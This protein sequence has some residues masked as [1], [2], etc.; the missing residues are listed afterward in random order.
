MF[1]TGSK[2]MIG[3]TALTTI[4][5]VAY[6]LAVGGT[7]GTIGLASAAVAL[8]F[9]SGIVI[10]I[11][12]ANVDVVDSAAAAR[13]AAG[14]QAPSA[15]LWPLVAI[16]GLTMVVVGL[17]STP[18]VFILGFVVLLAAGV[19]W[20]VQAWAEQ[21]SAD[22]TYNAEIRDRIIGPL[23]VPI[24]AALVGVLVIYAFSRIMLTLSKTGSIVAFS[25]VATIILIV[26]FLFA[27]RKGTTGR[28]IGGVVV[29]AVLALLVGGAVAAFNG[30]RNLYVLE[31]TA[32]L[33]ADGR[34]GPEASKADKLSSQT[35]GAKSSAAATVTLNADGSLTAVKPGFNESTSTLTLP[36]SNPNNILFRN[37]SDHERRL[38]IEIGRSGPD[39]ETR[40]MCTALV[41]PGAVQLMT[42]RFDKPSFAVD[43]GFEFT[44]PG[45][46]SATLEVVIP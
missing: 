46:D 42:V 11:R 3:A 1:T 21:T 24:L 39:E 36:R 18:A 16:V 22:D 30:E 4:F 44:V 28:R 31:T 7:L 40:T 33:A 19:E 35:V 27:S 9:L 10:Y 43:G 20:M 25:V 41:E 38:S 5:A 45:V 13:S 37:E 8:A 2:L 29:I 12:D 32:D 15:S 14:R 17:V 34:C 23:E 26:A 6:G